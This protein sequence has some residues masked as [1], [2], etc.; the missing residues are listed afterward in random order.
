MMFALV[1]G[2]AIGRLIGEQMSPLDGFPPLAVFGASWGAMFLV[3]AIRYMTDGRMQKFFSTPDFSFLADMVGV[4][5]R[6]DFLRKVWLYTWLRGSV[7]A[8]VYFGLFIAWFHLVG[9]S[10]STSDPRWTLPEMN[11][12]AGYAALFL[13]SFGAAFLLSVLLRRAIAV[14]MPA[15]HAAVIV[16]QYLAVENDERRFERA[17]RRA[18]II[19]VLGTRR[20]L[21][22]RA[23]RALDAAAARIDLAF[24]QHPVASILRACSGRIHAFLAG[25][26]AVAGGC[27]D[28]MAE[29]LNKVVAVLAGPA[30]R[31]LPA[32]FAQALEAFD[33]DGVPVEQ[34]APKRYWSALAARAVDVVD[35]YSRLV[36]A[37]WGVFIL[38][39]AIYFLLSGSI[40]LSKIVPK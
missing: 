13:A 17:K 25:T 3:H 16:Q 23:A 37:L 18:G 38:A 34:A 14:A 31:R 40:T 29:M 20:V 36:A 27:S 12:Q 6:F 28:E 15:V 5:N 8:G 33:P 24:T 39:T 1:A 32:T 30:D 19:D 7:K 2:R 10:A 9:A 21:L 26:K 11:G 22:A 4:V 35:R